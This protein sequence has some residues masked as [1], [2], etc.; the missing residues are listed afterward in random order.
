MKKIII[1]IDS[2]SI[3]NTG[4][5]THLYHL[6]VD[7][8]KEKHPEIEKLLIYSSKNVLDRLPDYDFIIKKS[9]YFLNRGKFFR[10]LFQL[11]FFDYF[12]K[13]NKVNFL[14]SITG[15]YV[16]NF[17]PY[18]GIS[19]NMLLYEREFW[20]EIKGL[21]EKIKL[22]INYNR[23]KKCFKSAK[24][25]IYISRYAKEYISNEL[26]L[27]IK[28]S[29]IIHHGS[30]PIFVNKNFKKLKQKNI[31]Y[32]FNFIYVSTIHVYKNQWNVIDAIWSLRQS[33]FDLSLTLIGPIIYAPSGR[34]LLKKIK[35][36]DPNN[37]FITYIPE[38]PYEKLPSYYSNHDAIIYASTCEN[39][40]N[41]L[42]ESMASGLPIACSN[43][44]PMPEFLKS[45]GYYFN[46]NSIDSIIRAIKEL[47][48]DK[49]PILKIEQNLEF[50]KNLKWEETSKKTFNF[51][52]YI[53][54]T[55]V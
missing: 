27:K 38:V 31:A 15:D 55:N 44:M 16:G 48:N 11:L 51:I 33:G 24:G 45:G 54:N 7:F 35:E 8:K 17:R 47:L 14:L 20:K 52:K 6:I 10:L 34:K 40:P 37:Q 22:W 49:Q 23:Q 21:K 29:K 4:G 13:K 9:H 18:V 28:P 50:I 12:L 41:I 42:I 36:K 5:F 30:S 3:V 39:M 32:K 46:A 53:A 1:S 26:N 2:T 43:K 25:I 19:Q